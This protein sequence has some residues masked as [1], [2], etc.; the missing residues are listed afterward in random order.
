VA[1]PRLTP[2]QVRDAFAEELETEVPKI[3]TAVHVAGIGLGEFLWVD[4][5]AR[6][7]HDHIGAFLVTRLEQPGVVR[8]PLVRLAIPTDTGP[9]LEFVDGAEDVCPESNPVE[10]DAG[11]EQSVGVIDLDVGGIGVPVRPDGGVDEMLPDHFQRRSDH[12][13]VVGEE[14]GFLGRDVLRPVDVRRAVLDV[15]NDRH[16][17]AFHQASDFSVVSRGV[18]TDSSAS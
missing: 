5:C 6:L 12:D 17:R 10:C 18:Q 14:I 13:V 11:A 3:V 1:I 4:A 16:D 7:F 9:G 15:L 8:Q 2:R